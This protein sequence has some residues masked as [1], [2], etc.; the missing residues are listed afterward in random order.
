MDTVNCM[1]PNKDSEGRARE[2]FNRQQ[3]ARVVVGD[4]RIVRH[5]DHCRTE[6]NADMKE[7]GT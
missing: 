1:Q 5:R 6:L 7:M 4:N 2:D 3:R